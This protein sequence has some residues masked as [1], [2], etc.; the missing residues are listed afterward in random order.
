M[1]TMCSQVNFPFKTYFFLSR[2]KPTAAVL[3]VYLLLSAENATPL[4]YNIL[5]RKICNKASK[6]NNKLVNV[7]T[8]KQLKL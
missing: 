2:S 4:L 1:R 8:F 7:I 5:S 6:Q 3:S